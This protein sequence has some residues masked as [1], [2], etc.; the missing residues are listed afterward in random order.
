MKQP[1]YLIILL[2]TSDWIWYGLIMLLLLFMLG[3]S[4]LKYFKKKTETGL[5][6]K[7]IELEGIMGNQQFL[8]GNL[9]SIKQYILQHSPLEAAQYLTEFTNLLKTLSNSSK[10]KSITLS[11]EIETILLYLELEKKRVGEDFSFFQEIE[12]NIKTEAIQVK[13]LFAFKQV[14]ELIRKQQNQLKLHLIVKKV[15]ERLCCKVESNVL[16]TNFVIEIPNK[17]SA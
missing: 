10:Q 9:N 6:E 12:A 7:I 8:Y 17:Y 1:T 5:L 16:S 4:L 15:G 13:P 2:I 11:Q 3:F 14:E